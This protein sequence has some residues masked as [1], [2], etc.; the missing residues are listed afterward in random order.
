MDWALASQL[1]NLDVIEKIIFADEEEAIRLIN[2]EAAA[3]I[4]I[5]ENLSESIDC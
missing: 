4:I 3:A 2:E 1:R 5:P